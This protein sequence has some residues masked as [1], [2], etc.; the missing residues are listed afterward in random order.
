MPSE[1]VVGTFLLMLGVAFV[2]GV[3]L[4]VIPLDLI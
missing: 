4:G 2:L 3:A 1:W